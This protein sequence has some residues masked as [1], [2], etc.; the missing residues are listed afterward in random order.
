MKPAMKCLVPLL[1]LLLGAAP[2]PLDAQA[3]RP[4][5][6]G[7]C[8][9]APLYARHG[10]Y[11]VGARECMVKDAPAGR[12]LPATLWY[13]ALNPKGLKESDTV[14][15]DN[16]PL[17]GRVWTFEGH[18]L[19]DAAP[20]PTGGPYPLVVF[21][22]GDPGTR[23][24]AVPYMEHL[25]SYGF[26][27]LAADHGP[28][29][30]YRLEDLDAVV[31]LGERLAREGDFAKLIDMDRIAVA[32]Y[33]FG[34][35]AALR[36]GGACFRGLSVPPRSPR[37]KAV[38]LMAPGEDSLKSAEAL[39][40]SAATLPTLVLVG[41]KDTMV[42]FPVV[43]AIYQALPAEAK[44]RVRFTGGTHDIFFDPFLN[45]LWPGELDWNGLDLARTQDLINHFSTAFLMGV[46]KSD[47]GGRQA[48]QAA[49][50]HFSEVEYSSTWK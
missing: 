22:H 31:S 18:A 15:M 6:V 8:A 4:E 23:A 30:M 29:A 40:L 38:L 45:T 25:A 13:P 28:T 46:L 17:G 26:M 39:D 12:S 7:R 19:Q 27:V 44:G 36:A 1:T 5:P 9:D 42:H 3:P 11:W 16:R 35:L 48:L 50:T 34:G 10:P 33:S 43:E 32:G 49:A 21:S 41:D 14:T 37:L 20:D 24:D 47:A 2:P